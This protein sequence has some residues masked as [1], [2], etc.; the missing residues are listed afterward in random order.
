M[1]LYL[2]F[3][4]SYQENF[5]RRRHTMDLPSTYT[6]DEAAAYLNKIGFDDVRA[7][8]REWESHAWPGGYPLFYYTKDGG[9]LSPRAANSELART[10][11]P[12]DDQFFIVACD[13]NYEDPDLWC[14]HTN[15]RIPSAYCEDTK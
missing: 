14:D 4:F 11:D 15:E 1:T 13:I 9:V 8:R 10:L 12:N 7:I 5:E 3:I 6:W 2:N